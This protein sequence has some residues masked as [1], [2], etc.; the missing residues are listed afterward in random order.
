ME[1][2]AGRSREGVLQRLEVAQHI[3]G[4][5]ARVGAALLM[6]ILCLVP[7]V[8]QG[9]NGTVKQVFSAEGIGSKRYCET[10]NSY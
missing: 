3:R 8:H 6:A 10:R 9:G 4:C 2:S 1:C 5:G 7:G